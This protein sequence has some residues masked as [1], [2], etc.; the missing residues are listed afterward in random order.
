VRKP[1]DHVSTTISCMIMRQTPEF[2]AIWAAKEIPVTCFFDHL[3]VHTNVVHDAYLEDECNIVDDDVR[4]RPYKIARRFETKDSGIGFT[5]FEDCQFESEWFYKIQLNPNSWAWSFNS[6]ETF[7]QNVIGYVD[8]ANHQIARLDLAFSM[9]ESIVSTQLLYMTSHLKWK[10]SNS[11][12]N[13]KRDFNNGVMTGY[14]SNGG[15]ARSSIYSE[16]AKALSLGRTAREEDLKF[17]VQLRKSSLQ[18]KSIYSIYDLWKIPDSNLLERVEF[19]NPLWLHEKHRRHL[20]KFE[21]LQEKVVFSG[22]QNARKLLNHG[23]NFNRDYGNILTKLAINK[24]KENLSDLMRKEFS[25]WLM[26]WM[27]ETDLDRA[28]E[29]AN[30]RRGWLSIRTPRPPPTKR[31]K[32][33]LRRRFQGGFKG[34]L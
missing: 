27:G 3:S 7:M 34:V 5:L 30:A 25:I 24:G 21:L 6:I 23:R 16:G 1:K 33:R 8:S 17:E 12:Y 31:R 2:E 19:Y 9:P 22:F 4:S 10:N 14:H 18:P 26:D 11:T 15:G 29:I 28:K 32:G 13:N 20:A